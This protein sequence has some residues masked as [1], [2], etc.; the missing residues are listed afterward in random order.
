MMKRSILITFTSILFPLLPFIVKATT[1]NGNSDKV[2]STSCLKTNFE[3]VA[4]VQGDKFNYRLSCPKLSRIGNVVFN[5]KKGQN[6]DSLCRL[7]GFG[8]SDAR[9]VKDHTDQRYI[10]LQGWYD[11]CT[12]M[13]VTIEL[14]PVEE[15]G[16]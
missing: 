14:Y 16:S 8:R 6:N 3:F 4:G 1:L 7:I 13:I 9:V 15:D 11:G 5:V 2:S 10:E 12:A